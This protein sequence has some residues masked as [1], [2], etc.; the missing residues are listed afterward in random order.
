MEELERSLTFVVYS[1]PTAILSRIS[2]RVGF[3][4]S[5]VSSLLP[6]LEI[7]S[8]LFIIQKTSK[9]TGVGL[10]FLHSLEHNRFIKAGLQT[11]L[12]EAFLAYLEFR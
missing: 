8:T 11:G 9:K 1:S 2:S 3:S 12:T 5:E 7:Y 6:I 4:H 10:C